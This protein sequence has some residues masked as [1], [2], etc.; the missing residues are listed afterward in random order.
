MTNTNICHK[1][2]N[3]ENHTQRSENCINTAKIAWAKCRAQSAVKMKIAVK[4]RREK[5]QC[6]KTEKSQCDKARNA[7]QM[8]R[9]KPTNLLLREI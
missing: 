7:R 9:G 6:R 4:I 3:A 8:Q 1:I 5:L 2:Y